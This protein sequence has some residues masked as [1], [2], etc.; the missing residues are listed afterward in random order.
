MAWLTERQTCFSKFRGRTS[1]LGVH[2]HFSLFYLL[3]SLFFSC[4]NPFDSSHEGRKSG[5]GSLSLTINGANNSRTIQP[6]EGILDTLD[7]K[8]YTLAFTP[9]AGGTAHSVDIT[10]TSATVNLDARTYSVQV[11]AYLDEDKT[12]PAAA[13]SD[14][15]IV[16]TAGQNTSRNIPLY[17]LIDGK[18]T[19]T[20]AWEISFAEDAGAGLKEARIEISELDNT[21]VQTLYLGEIETGKTPQ[22]NMN[23]SVE[24]YSGDYRLLF[25]FAKDGT[26]RI[27]WRESLHVYENLTSA[28]AY[29]FTENHFNNISYTV[30]FV[31]NDGVT[32]DMVQTR[33][34]DEK[35]TPPSPD[36]TYAGGTFDRW[37]KDPALTT[38]W[39]FGTDT[40][41]ANTTLYAKWI[42]HQYTVNFEHVYDG[43]YPIENRGEP[44]I[45]PHGGKVSRPTP[46][47]SVEGG[48]GFVGWYKEAACTTP[49]YFDD[50][51]VIEDTTLYA[52]WVLQLTGTV[53]IDADEI[54]GAEVTVE[55]WSGYYL[56]GWSDGVALRI[57]INGDDLS[58]ARLGSGVH[59]YYTFTVDAG[60]VVTFYWV[61]EHGI[62]DED[63]AFAVYYSDDPPAAFNPE[64]GTGTTD[65][66]KVLAY[67]LYD[68]S[69]RV[70]NNTPMGSFAVATLSVG[71]TLTANTDDLDGSGTVSYQWKRG[72]VN[73]GTNSDTYDIQ[74][75]DVDSTITVTV[76][77]ADNSGSVTSDPTPFIGIPVT[78]SE[79]NGIT[80]PIGGATPVS[81]ITPTREYTG[82][83]TWNPPVTGTF[84]EGEAYTAT[85]ALTPKQGFTLKGVT[86]DFFYVAEAE[87]V[88]Y[89][90]N[91]GVVT[92]EFPVYSPEE[93]A[94]RL[95]DYL[96]ELNLNQEWENEL[97][98]EIVDDCIVIVGGSNT[99][100]IELDIPAGVTVRWDA[101]IEN[102]QRGWSF[103]LKGSGILEITDGAYLSCG[104]YGNGILIESGSPTLK[105]AGGEI[106]GGSTAIKTTRGASPVIEISGGAFYGDIILFGGGTIT[107]SGT[108]NMQGEIVRDAN[109]TVTGYYDNDTNK[110]VFGYGWTEEENLFPMEE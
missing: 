18:G 60:D 5:T 24:L 53:S 3:F 27:E 41:T 33:L 1:H 57:N 79:I 10:S 55:M 14:T 107:V 2:L 30:T 82:S 19:G 15:G 23:D 12:E 102:S 52:K 97:T 104:G 65:I 29:T 98:V 103:T 40:V 96:L 54:E 89:N 94:K 100:N 50:D 91:S 75:G 68:P 72:T 11:T 45:V 84:L 80:V 13:G 43:G 34:H 61:N 44:V 108:P 8:V 32:P 81:T 74:A 21:P 9:T 20:F 37:Y 85:I 4:S 78:I 51:V 31:Y 48:S 6:V 99:Y 71:Q 17:A 56:G 69:G 105:I 73:I 42:L 49:W 101:R 66:D 83:V 38:A 16:I 77:R 62:G 88:T 47:P 46:D 28:F 36:P 64:T 92:A 95:E 59:N 22:K 67:K 7:W 26:Q 109:A 63:A 35:A 25:V 93:R 86:T 90:A 106:W 87:T 70:R 58:S 76:T 39:Q 110:A